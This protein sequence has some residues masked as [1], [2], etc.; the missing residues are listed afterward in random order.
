M[1]G[2]KLVVESV[3]FRYRSVR[4][5]ASGCRLAGVI[6]WEPMQELV[7]IGC[8]AMQAQAL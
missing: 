8:P 7:P 5:R 1:S 4:A 3:S 6:I 2:C